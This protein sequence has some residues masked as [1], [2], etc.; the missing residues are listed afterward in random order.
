MLEDPSMEGKV[1]TIIGLR[2]RRFSDRYKCLDLAK[3]ANNILKLS[4]MLVAAF[5]WVD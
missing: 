5:Q 4:A 1:R 2:R 3:V